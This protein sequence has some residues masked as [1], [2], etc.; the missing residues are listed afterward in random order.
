M[1]ADETND[2]PAD[3]GS[4]AHPGLG[5]VYV[6]LLLACVLVAAGGALLLFADPPAARWVAAHRDDAAVRTFAHIVTPLG[7]NPFYWLVVAALAAS[8]WVARRR[9]WLRAAGLSA[10]AFVLLGGTGHIIKLLTHRV[11]PRSVDVFMPRN[12]HEFLFTGEY[13]SFPS[14]D[15]TIAFALVTICVLVAWRG[16]WR[17]LV[18]VIPIAVAVGRVLRWAHYPSDCLGGA[19]LGGLGAYVMCCW[20]AARQGRSQSAECRTQNDDA[21]DATG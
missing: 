1:C 3:A 5:P 9:E 7:G 20:W 21:P 14:G 12:W 8:G 6:W 16:W 2:P 19:V 17:W 10:A 4:D 11:R 13:H 18:F 15:V